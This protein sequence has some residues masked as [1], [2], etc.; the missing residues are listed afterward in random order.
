MKNLKPNYQTLIFVFAIILLGFQTNAQHMASVE[1]DN[2]SETIISID[3]NATNVNISIHGD[4]HGDHGSNGYIKAQTNNNYRYTSHFSKPLTDQ[5]EALV[6][7]ELGEPTSEMDG[8]KGWDKIDGESI[9][10]LSVS[11]KAGKVK[12]I[13][14]YENVEIMKRLEDL[15]KEICKITYRS[16]C[17]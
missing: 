1:T 17:D 11:L 4:Y 9:E 12:I 7:K 2:E 6:I 3:K 10:G 5:I 16:N 13:Y 15:T 14:K 8:V